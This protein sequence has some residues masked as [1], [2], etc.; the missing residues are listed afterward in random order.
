MH[1][2]LQGKY[3]CPAF[4]LSKEGLGVFEL[5][6]SLICIGICNCFFKNAKYFYFIF[7]CCSLPVMQVNGDAVLWLQIQWN[8]TDTIQIPNRKRKIFNIYFMEFAYW[9]LRLNDLNLLKT[10]LICWAEK[11]WLVLYWLGVHWTTFSS[12]ETTYLTQVSI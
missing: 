1:N 9:L 5:I 2:I 11:Y 4:L 6:Y 8:Q 7:I 3:N 10:H 12:V